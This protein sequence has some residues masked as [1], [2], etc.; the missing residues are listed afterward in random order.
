MK[1]ILI[2]CFTLLSL[3]AIAQPAIWGG[4]KVKLLQTDTSF[5]TNLNAVKNWL[6]LSG[7]GTVSSFGAGTLSPLF[8]TSVANSTTTPALSFVLTN[9]A[10]NTYFGNATGSA[11]APS[12]TAAGALTKTDD[13]NVTLTLGG[14]ASTSLLRAASITVGWA[15]ILA[16][17]RGGTN[18]GFTAFTGPSAS[19]KTFTLP[20]AT[21]TILTT[22]AAVTAPQG[23][24][25]QTSYAVGDI[26]FASTTSALSKLADI[27]TGNALITGGVNVAPTYG[28]IGLTTHVSGTLPVGNGGNGLTAVGS[29]VTL[30]GSNGTA[31]IYYTLARTTNSAAI[32]W[33]RSSTT[34][35]FNLPPADISFE[36]LVSTTTQSFAGNKTFTGTVTATG[37]ATGNGG[38]R[39]V[40]TASVAALNAGGV[41]DGDYAT[42]TTT[43]TLNHTNNY[44]EIGTLSANITINLP[45]CN[46]TSD[47]WEYEFLKVGSDAFAFILDPNSTET[48][49]DNALTKT[50]FS[51]G[52]GANCKCKSSISKWFYKPR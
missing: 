25:G 47:G 12:Y 39:G 6:G 35:N 27:A 42:I 16:P 52:N 11:T 33:S 17:S 46:A 18:N 37:L 20:N 7:G 24:T 40:A 48:F 14:N 45:A 8:T 4:A 49:F 2:F 21:A 26:L 29:D 50:V 5:E 30:L 44:V 1:K 43:T 34:L 10:A 51:Q 41:M 32:G 23:G 9:A 38:I 15:G 36:G 19:T 31:N 22:N 28:K 3:G 13:T